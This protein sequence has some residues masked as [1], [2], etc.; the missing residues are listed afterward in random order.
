MPFFSR[1]KIQPGWLAVGLDG[2]TAQFTYVRDGPHRPQVVYCETRRIDPG[3]PKR[4]ER[5][6]KEFEAQRHRVT[7]LIPPSGY[8]ILVLDAPAVKPDEL[9]PALRWRIKDLI[10]FHIDDAVI[11]VLDIPGATSGPPR[12]QSLNAV[13]AK[14]AAVQALIA[15]FEAARLPLEVID[16]PDAAQ[17]NVASLFE[18]AERGVVA[19]SFDATG[20]L[21]TFTGGGEL[22]LSRRIDLTLDQL[23]HAEEA[24]RAGAFE[25]ALVE[26]QR[27]LDHF[28]R[29]VRHMAVKKVLLA[30]LH[31]PGDALKAH[32]RQGLYVPVAELALDEALDLPA[33]PA[34]QDR[35][36]HGRWLKL[37][38]AALRDETKAL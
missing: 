24:V 8:Q 36:S 34:L 35:A 25:R 30:P 27:S 17:R 1:N 14:S 9:R 26:L 11:D 20:G 29:Q 10:D 38:G 12:S 16:I 37:I 4:L 31:A 23:C 18:S 6:G 13:V 15:R 33:A 19:V 5:A 7:T 3:D 32:L 2:E 21:I 28:E 22:Y